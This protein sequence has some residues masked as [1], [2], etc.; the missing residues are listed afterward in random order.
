MGRFRWAIVRKPCPEMVDGISTAGLGKPDYRLALEQ[1][2]KYV[3]ALEQCGLQVQVLESDSRYPDS[4][5]IED[6]ALCTPACAVVTRPG[7]PTRRGETD[8]IREVLAA[9]YSDI[10]EI[11]EPGTLEA[12]DVMM[13]GSHYY[14]GLSARTNAEGAR[15]LIEI[16][17]RHGM[18][19]EVVPLSDVLH[20]KTGV[21]YL[22]ENR[23]LVSGEFTGNRSFLT[24]DRI[25]VPF[26]EA[27]AANSLWLNGTV[28]VPAG[29][30]ETKA[31][32][33]AKGYS[34]IELDLSEYKKLDGGL[35]CLSLR[36]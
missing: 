25:E 9:Y 29:F 1:H 17:R 6:V 28:L 11:R 36:F 35:S 21:S 24:F 18:T 5:F 10:E 4:V 27:Y 2:A 22:E 15:Q 34:T 3:V 16:L 31:R 12:G 19:G 7:A 26:G 8:G 20:L 32:I 23:M 33:M 30:P 14:I 13:A